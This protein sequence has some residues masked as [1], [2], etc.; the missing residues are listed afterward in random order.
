MFSAS[1]L[2]LHLRAAASLVF[3]GSGSKSVV[4]VQRALL[5]LVCWVVRLV[6]GTAKLP[7]ALGYRSFHLSKFKDDPQ[8]NQENTE[9]SKKPAQSVGPGWVDVGFVELQRLVLHHWKDEGT[10]TNSRGDVKP[11]I[12]HQWPRTIAYHVF[13]VVIEI[14]C[15]VYPSNCYWLTHWEEEKIVATTN[16]MVKKLKEIQAPL[17]DEKESE[18]EAH[19]AKA[20]QQQLSAIS[21]S[22]HGREHVRHWGHQALETHKLC[23]CTQQDDHDEETYR[24]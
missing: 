7:E 10:Q 16:I 15:A 5:R 14:V 22:K 2:H 19:A 24:P 20:E 18:K 3:V 8:R 13:N 23:I 6:F 17:C 21:S 4:W 1:H 9:K 12:L 11:A